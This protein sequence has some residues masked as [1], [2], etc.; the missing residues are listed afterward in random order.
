MVL[1]FKRNLLRITYEEKVVGHFVRICL[2]RSYTMA[3]KKIPFG[4]T[5]SISAGAC[6]FLVVMTTVTGSLCFAKSQKWLKSYSDI[7]RSVFMEDHT[8]SGLG[9]VSGIS[10]AQTPVSPTRGVFLKSQNDLV[11]FP[12]F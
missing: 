4:I 6:E 10:T 8:P 12:A 7:H 9:Q 11:H 2:A 3:K 1:K 5:L